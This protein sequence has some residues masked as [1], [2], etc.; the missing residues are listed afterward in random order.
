MEIEANVKR[1]ATNQIG[2][3]GGNEAFHFVLERRD[4]FDWG[5][6]WWWFWS[7][8][9]IAIRSILGEK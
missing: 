7:D 6:D 3:R 4:S 5:S 9:A 2:L 1:M 8:V